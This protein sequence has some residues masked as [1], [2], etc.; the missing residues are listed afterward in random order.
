MA[1]DRNRAKLGGKVVPEWPAVTGPMVPEFP[2]HD[3]E[4]TDLVSTSRIRTE[5]QAIK[6]GVNDPSIREQLSPVSGRQI[7]NPSA[8]AEQF[9]P[10]PINIV[11]Q[12]ERGEHGSESAYQAAGVDVQPGTVA[13]GLPEDQSFNALTR[14]VG[15]MVTG[16]DP[17]AQDIAHKQ[18]N[19]IVAGTLMSGGEFP[20]PRAPRVAIKDWPKDEE[21]EF[22]QNSPDPGKEL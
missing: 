9:Q 4:A 15:D 13:G 11:P 6:E 20:K 12:T 16:P 17:K 14:L 5:Q 22:V 10:R 18:I 3:W 19:E 2:P 7:P 1:I 8:N 21:K